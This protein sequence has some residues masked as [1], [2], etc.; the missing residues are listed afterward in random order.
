MPTYTYFCSHC[1]DRFDV[2]QLMSDT[3]ID[4]CPK[5]QSPVKRLIG[6]NVG[7]QFIGSGFYINDSQN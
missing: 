3:A 4:S 1:N 6:Q 7:I 5:C 2:V